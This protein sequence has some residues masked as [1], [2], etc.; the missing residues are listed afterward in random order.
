MKMTSSMSLVFYIFYIFIK[1]LVK[2][3]SKKINNK[4]KHFHQNPNAYPTGR[5][6]LLKVLFVCGSKIKL[7]KQIFLKV[8]QKYFQISKKSVFPCDLSGNKSMKK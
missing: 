4:T 8:I 7:E 3:T 6:H 2:I 1:I 5:M